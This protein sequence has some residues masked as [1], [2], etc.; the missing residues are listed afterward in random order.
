MGSDA[1]G[2]SDESQFRPFT[3]LRSYVLMISGFGLIGWGVPDGEMTS[4]GQAGLYR[5]GYLQYQS[6]LS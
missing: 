1:L 2:G 6:Y 3:P 4:N 5:L